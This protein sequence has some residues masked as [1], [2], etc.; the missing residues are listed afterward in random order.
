MRNGGAQDSRIQHV[1]A[2]RRRRT[3]RDRAEIVDP[4]SARPGCRYTGS[5]RSWR[6][7]LPVGAASF[8]HR[9][10]V[11]DMAGVATQI[12]GQ[13][14][15]DATGVRVGLLGQQR[16]WATKEGRADWLEPPP[17]VVAIPI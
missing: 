12:V 5:S 17:A 1:L 10:D 2:R 9:C 6:V 13:G 11:Q 16:A 14:R 15:A 4:Q 3:G 7:G 8:E